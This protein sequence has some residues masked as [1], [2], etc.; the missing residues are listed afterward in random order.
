MS[1]V[2]VSSDYSAV[3]DVVVDL[4]DQVVDSADD[5]GDI[6]LVPMGDPSFNLGSPSCLV[7]Q[8]LDEPFFID[9]Y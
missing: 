7:I 1:N 9:R 5:C 6:T 8:D 4:K 2:D 3:C